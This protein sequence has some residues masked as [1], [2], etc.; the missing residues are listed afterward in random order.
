MP[1]GFLLYEN[2]KNCT[3]YSR[4]QSGAVT[5]SASEWMLLPGFLIFPAGTYPLSIKR[6]DNSLA[7]TGFSC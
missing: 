4:E 7:K 3:A 2:N 6:A 5:A 1:P